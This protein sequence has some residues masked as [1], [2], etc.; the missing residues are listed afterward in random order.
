[1][2]PCLPPDNC[3]IKLQLACIDNL[4]HP[5]LSLDVV[6]NKVFFNGLHL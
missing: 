5:I 4:S 6:L 1:M 3:N 2:I